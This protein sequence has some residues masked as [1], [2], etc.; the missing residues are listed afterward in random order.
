AVIEDPE[1]ALAPVLD[2]ARPANSRDWASDE[3]CATGVAANG[4]YAYADDRYAIDPLDVLYPFDD[5]ALDAGYA[6]YAGYGG[7]LAPPGLAR[8]VRVNVCIVH[9]GDP[10]RACR[11]AQL[12]GREP[13]LRPRIRT[14]QTVASG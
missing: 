14:K 12:P 10:T 6:G 7:Y 3:L 1:V 11:P 13:P 2:A 5:A 4:T 9:S 8:P